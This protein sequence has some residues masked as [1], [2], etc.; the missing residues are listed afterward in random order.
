MRSAYI[1]YNLVTNRRGVYMLLFFSLLLGCS[2]HMVA[3]VAPRE[4]DILVYPEHINFGHLI[5]GVEKEEDT[6]T[7]INTGDGDLK[8]FSPVLVSGNTRYT[9]ISEEEEYTIPGGELMDFVVEYEPGTFESNGA[10]IDIQ[11]NDED[12]PLSRVTLEGYGD[13]PVM[14]VFPEEFNYGDISIGCDN[15]ERIT[16]RNDG[17]LDLEISDVVQMVTQPADIIMEMGSLPELPWTLLPGE[18]LDFLVSYV[19]TNVGT[20]ESQISI[21]G[22]DPRTPEIVT[23]QVGIGDV[24]H[25]YAEHWIQEKVSV[26]DIL[27]VVDDSGSMMPFQ[28]NLSSNISSFL[29]IFVSSGVD[30]HMAVITTTWHSF[31]SFVDDSTLNAAAVM[32]NELMVGVSGS[33]NEKGLEMAELALTIGSARPGGGFYR[34]DAKLVVIFVSDEPDFSSHAQSINHYITFFDSLKAPGQFIP[35]GV[36]GDVPSG[37]S[38]PWNNY[39]R[40]ADPGYG[41]WELIE[42]YGSKWYSICAIDWGVQ[43][44]EIANEIYNRR[45]FEL[46]KP[47]PIEDTIQVKVNGQITTE[48]T[49]DSSINSVIFNEDHVP[50]ENQTI[51]IEYATWGCG[52][53]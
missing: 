20:D 40:H 26:I 12:E 53:A 51:L 13:A 6:F 10:Y 8:I 33:G 31:N 16:I 52:G 24:E 7:V 28:Q 2:D 42:H 15:E 47:D 21:E 43:L 27:W 35:V 3:K 38:I 41:Y 29:N 18:E 37:C 25:W 48:W 11:S 50:E 22:S 46:T 34:N 39:V 1:C 19:P 30:F 9:L 23:T 44:Q 5:S 4:P 32:S 17:N 36:I 14:T 49:Y 45:S